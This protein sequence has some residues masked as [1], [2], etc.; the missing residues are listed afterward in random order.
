M[1]TMTL[2]GSLGLAG[3]YLAPQFCQLRNVARLRRTCRARKAV[4]LTYDDGPGPLLTPQLLT[5]LTRQQVKATFF[6]VGSCAEVAPDL[7]DRLLKDGHELGCHTY[8]H[9]HAWKSAPWTVAADVARGFKSLDRWGQHGLPFRPPYGKVTAATSVAMLGRASNT[10][11]W[12][13]DS[14]DTWPTLPDP[15][16]VA[17][18]VVDDGG[19]VVLLHDFDRSADRADY[20]LKTTECLIARARTEGLALMPLRDLVSTGTTHT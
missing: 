3:L 12:T 9:R 18:R 2:L 15:E 17:T 20:V 13:V 10:F 19:G 8:S 1:I 7:L 6:S 5:L 16:T 4:V 11:W 14:G